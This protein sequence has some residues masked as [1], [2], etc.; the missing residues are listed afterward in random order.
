MKNRNVNASSAEAQN[1]AKEIIKQ[2]LCEIT[3]DL[4]NNEEIDFIKR[5]NDKI[6][7]T[8]VAVKNTQSVDFVF[9]SHRTIKVTVDLIDLFDDRDWIL[10]KLAQLFVKFK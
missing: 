2:G 5:Q 7:A 6:G 4:L 10:N 3:S 8:I 9:D 1:S